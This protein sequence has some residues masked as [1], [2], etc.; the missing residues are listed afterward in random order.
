MMSCLVSAGHNEIARL[1]SDMGVDK[2]VT[3]WH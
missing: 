2:K 1:P 3:N